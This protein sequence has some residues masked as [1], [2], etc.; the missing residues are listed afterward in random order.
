MKKQLGILLLAFIA[1]IGLSG[2]VA[3]QPI[4]GLMQ[5]NMQGHMQGSM[6]GH[7]PGFYHGFHPGFHN[8]HWVFACNWIHV[9]HPFPHWIHICHWVWR[10]FFY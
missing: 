6:Y 7:G 5:G 1:I 3:A 9:W 8:G 10:P 4:H 2:A